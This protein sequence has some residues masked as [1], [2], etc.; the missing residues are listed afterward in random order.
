M[1]YS[2]RV[3]VSAV[4]AT[5]ME[6]YVIGQCRKPT[7]WLGR[8][9]VRTMNR[10]HS[11][12]TSWGLEHVQVGKHDAVLDVGC[13]GGQTVHRLAHMADLG[14][15][16]GVDY[17]E[18]S[19]AASQAF[20]R[21]AVESGRVEI[22]RAAV[23]HLPFPNEVFNLVTAVETHYYWPDLPGDMR[24]I[25]RVLKPGGSVLIIAEAYRGRRLD[26]LYAVVMKL[27]RAAYLSSD[28]HRDLLLKAGYADAQV[29]LERTKGWLC[30]TGR[31]PR[32]PCQDAAAHS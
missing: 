29:F 6:W 11:N 17:A 27:I 18:A 22:Q 32:L 13:G 23:S 10:S 19:V 8:V 24:E 21:A 14:K 15:V 1:T 5:V 3:L 12:L 7:G 4:V 2:V 25:Y 26:W 31:K 20:N 16:H 28:D 9:M 30:A